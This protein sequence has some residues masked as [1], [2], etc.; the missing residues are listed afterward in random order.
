VSVTVL[1]DV[2]GCLTDGT[3]YVDTE[4]LESLRF[5][6]RDAWLLEE[7]KA[8]GIT[9]AWVTDDPNP[10]P[11][12]ER[13]AKLGLTLWSTHRGEARA[14]E[15][16]GP[17]EWRPTRL[18][19]KVEVVKHYKATGARVVYIGDAPAD[20]EAM[21]AADEAWAPRAARGH[22]DG[23]CWF[24]AVAGGSGVLHEVLADL[25]GRR[26]VA[27]ERLLLGKPSGAKR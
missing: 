8:A 11:A 23:E 21:R 5:S 18:R 4:G 10:Y 24:T 22:L 14:L 17:G 3:V 19:S 25:L 9:V 2:D 26:V 13:A 12:A 7:A 20:L 15:Y 6:K 16:A 27:G 1:C